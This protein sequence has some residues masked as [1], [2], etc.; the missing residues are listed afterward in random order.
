M[1]DN[2]KMISIH[3]P[4]LPSISCQLHSMFWSCELTHIATMAGMAHKVKKKII[5]NQQG[6]SARSLPARKPTDAAI[7]YI[8]GSAQFGT[9]LPMLRLAHRTMALV[10]Q[11][12]PQETDA[13]SGIKTT[14]GQGLRVIHETCI[15][16]RFQRTNGWGG[17]EKCGG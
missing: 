17:H 14:S 10:Y 11:K 12:R 1:K 5:I 6:L 7:K 8:N 2:E 15:S 9:T 3:V 16:G 13:D 4:S